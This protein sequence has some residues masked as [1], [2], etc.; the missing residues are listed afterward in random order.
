M[1]AV[2]EIT[3]PAVEAI[4]RSKSIRDAERIF[5]TQ[6]ISGAPIRDGIG[7]LAGFV[8]KTDIIGFDSTG[9]DSTYTRLKLP[10]PR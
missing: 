10:I 8:S 1:R 3:T 2:S 7:N 9:E 6:N 4:H 5:V